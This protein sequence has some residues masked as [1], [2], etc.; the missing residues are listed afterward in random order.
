[1]ASLRRENPGHER[2]QRRLKCHAI[3]F[4][5]NPVL[6]FVQ[7]SA[8]IIGPISIDPIAIRLLS[9]FEHALT[10]RAIDIDATESPVQALG[11]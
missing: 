10:E 4:I 6:C 9:V 11:A 7:A 3:V 5:F 2:S 1:M 8:I